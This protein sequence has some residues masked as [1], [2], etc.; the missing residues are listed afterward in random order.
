MG[1]NKEWTLWHLSPLE[2]WV[3]GDEKND[4][5]PET[6]V[7][8]PTDRLVTCRF[9]EELSSMHSR[10]DRHLTEEWR[11]HDRA[12]VEAALK[13]WGPCPEMF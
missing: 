9:K 11:S 6:K 12:A 4:S 5:Q 1:L 2:G 13:Q 3:R 10:V 8:P 7:D